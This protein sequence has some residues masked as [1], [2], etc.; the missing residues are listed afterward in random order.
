MTKFV[1]ILIIGFISS[2]SL[3]SNVKTT[4]VEVITNKFIFNPIK[5]QDTI[6]HTFLI[7]NLSKNPLIIEAVGSSCGCVVT[8]FSKNPIS[9]NKFAEVDITFTPEI[10][11]IGKIRKAILVKCNIQKNYIPFH[12]E[13]FVIG[14]SSLDLK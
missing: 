12:I 9:K 11:Q 1:Y 7:K 14:K 10:N 8:K 3:K 5:Y 2:C 6:K 13:G 4:Q